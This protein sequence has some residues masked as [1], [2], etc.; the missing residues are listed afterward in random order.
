MCQVWDFLCSALP[1]QEHML[2]VHP[3]RLERERFGLLGDAAGMLG[4]V[5]AVHLDQPHHDVRMPVKAVAVIDVLGVVEVVLGILGER[6][7][8]LVQHLAQVEAACG[9]PHHRIGVSP[10]VVA[11]PGAKRLL[12]LGTHQRLAGFGTEHRVDPSVKAG[13]DR[14]G[15]DSSRLGVCTVGHA[16][17]RNDQ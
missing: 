4:A 9:K 15:V 10:H 7:I 13:Q 11:P 16:R 12:L 5:G 17:R 14:F 6:G 2:R 3:D 1:S 8:G